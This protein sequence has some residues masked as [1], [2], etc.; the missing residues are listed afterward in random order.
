MEIDEIHIFD[1]TGCIFAV[2]NPDNY[3]LTLDSG[4]QVRFFYLC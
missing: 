3:G 1:E 2:T 4:E